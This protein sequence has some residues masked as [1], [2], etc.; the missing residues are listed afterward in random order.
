MTSTTDWMSQ[1]ITAI[2]KAAETQGQIKE[3]KRWTDLLMSLGAMR[4]S[5]LGKDWAVIYTENGAV[6][7]KLDT[8]TG[9][10][11]VKKEEN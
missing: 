7:I 10:P 6:D 5:M 11:A 4:S 9:I 8:L 3:V 1:R 2:E